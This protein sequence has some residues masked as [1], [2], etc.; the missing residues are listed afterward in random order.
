VADELD[1]LDF[2]SVKRVP[3]LT[4]VL[5]LAAGLLAGC[6]SAT[7]HDTAQTTQAP[8]ARL[9]GGRPAHI[10]VI[11]MENEEYGDIIGSRATPTSPGRPTCLVF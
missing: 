8:I 10:A 2:D 3:L 4:A 5:V 1:G 11:L 9:P 6:G 7:R